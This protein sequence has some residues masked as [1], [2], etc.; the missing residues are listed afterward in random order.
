MEKSKKVHILAALILFGVI[1]RAP[2][3]A[4]GTVL[5]DVRT[6]LGLSYGVA[7]LL[8]TIPV[9]ICALFSIPVSRL[10]IRRGMVN[11]AML[12]MAFYIVGLLLR[13]YGGMAGMLLGTAAMGA[14]MCIVNVLFPSIIKENFPQRIGTVTGAYVTTMYLFAAVAASASVPIAERID[15]RFSLCIWLPVSLAALVTWALLR[16][17]YR[18]SGADQAPA[19]GALRATLRLPR[20]VWIVALMASQAL[21]YY[22]SLSWLPTIVQGAG[23]TA[24]QAGRFASVAQLCGIPGAIGISVVVSKFKEQ[25][26]P[27]VIV[28]GMFLSAVLLLAFSRST[29]GFVLCTA[30]LGVSIAA[31]YSLVMCIIPLRTGTPREAVQLTGAVL[32]IGYAIA[33]VGP[34]LMGRLYDFSG[35]WLPPLGVLALASVCF[36]VSGLVAGKEG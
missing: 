13:S 16:S 7:G 35:S 19:A 14:G 15:W 34:A 22:C 2:L 33:A 5:E 26:I 29:A 10:R 25:R 18:E 8:T 21:I 36:A 23:Y 3:A 11:S 32:S 12:G 17:S 1:S 9:I 30:L 6:D 24:V 20:A 31:G 4:V 28:G 27:C